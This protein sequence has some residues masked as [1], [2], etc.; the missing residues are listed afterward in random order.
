L[1]AL[2]S[3]LFGQREELPIQT[4]ITSALLDLLLF[5]FSPMACLPSFNGIVAVALLFALFVQ[6]ALGELIALLLEASMSSF[7]FFV[8]VFF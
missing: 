6:G 8:L 4:N 3:I 7:P 1:H 2:P 5:F